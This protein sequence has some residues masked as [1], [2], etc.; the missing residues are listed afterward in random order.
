M[1]KEEGNTN[2]SLKDYLCVE[3]ST[4]ESS[5]SDEETKEEDDKKE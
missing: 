2:W 3:S 4:D 5:T 1:L